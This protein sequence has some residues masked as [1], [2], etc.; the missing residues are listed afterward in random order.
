MTS[1]PRLRPVAAS[2]VTV[3]LAAAMLAGAGYGQASAGRYE[4]QPD[5][6]RELK[7]HLTWQRA[8][9]ANQ[10]SFT[11]AGQLCADLVLGGRDDWRMP[12][13]QE[14]QTIVD[15]GR[16]RPAIDPVAFPGTPAEDFWTATPWAETPLL[17]WHV[18]FATG[19]AAYERVSVLYWAR[20]VRWDP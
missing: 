17:A 10:V 1:M 20:C 19:T 9:A 15:D 5:T 14:L 13:M 18:D 8:V 7:T 11:A 3:G 6:V 16:A 2:V 12:S 4:I